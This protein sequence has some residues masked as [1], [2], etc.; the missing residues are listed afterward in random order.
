MLWKSNG[1]KIIIF[2]VI[3]YILFL[4]AAKTL[5][6]SEAANSTYREYSSDKKFYIE[7]IPSEYYG[8]AGK[9]IAFSVHTGKQLWEVH[10]YAKWVMLAKDGLHLIRF[11]PWA[12]DSRNFSDLAV[13]FYKEG[14]EIKRYAVKEL[15]RDRSEI[16]KT[17]SHY[18]WSNYEKPPQFS[19]DEKYFYLHM[20]D[21]QTHTF[22]VSTG[23]MVK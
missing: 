17:V 4:T 16:F 19:S 12:K 9:G 23:E 6:D 2:S 21:G 7:M 11:G 20:I 18:I 15:L 5:A 10:W 13:F 1:A 22:E 14:K 8:E 3:L